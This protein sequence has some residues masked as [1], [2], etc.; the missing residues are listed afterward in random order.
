VPLIALYTGARLG[1]I[2]Q[3]ETS[4]VIEDE[5]SGLFLIDIKERLEEFE[6]DDPATKNLNSVRRVPV[7]QQLV[8]LGFIE[9]HKHICELG[10]RVL[11]PHRP[12]NK[13]RLD[14]PGKLV[15]RSFGE[16]LDLVGI[17]SPKKVFHSIRHTVITHLHIN[18]VPLGDAEL[19]VGH[20]SQD[21]YQ[22]LAGA[23][24]AAGSSDTHL[25]TYIDAAGFGS[26]EHDLEPRLKAHLDHALRYKLDFAGLREAAQIVQE[27]TRRKPDG[28]FASGWHTNNKR[29][30]QA[31]LDR[32]AK[33]T[34]STPGPGQAG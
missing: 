31:M 24:R 7:A 15:G 8:E 16:H 18:G 28:S 13:T 23:S 9:Y 21:R 19:V 14:D 3:L 22:W 27:H 25:H 34:A 20:A 12:M 10:A 29:H 5:Q 4:S 1:E 30:G 26:E 33:V 32:L 11:F 17:S 2:C 6:R